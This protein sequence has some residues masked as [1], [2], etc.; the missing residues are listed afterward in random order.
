MMYL[1]RL[2][3]KNWSAQEEIKNYPPGY[4]GNLGEAAFQMDI[5]DSSVAE[6]DKRGLID[7]NKVGIIGFSRSG[8]YTEFILAHAKVHYAAATA[9]DNIQYSLGEY[10][11]YRYEAN[12]RGYNSLYGGPPYGKSLKNWLDYSISFNLNKIRTPLLMEVMG[13]G[14]PYNESKAPPTN[15]ATKWEISS[16]LEQLHIP[17]ELY[18]YP[19]EEHQPD[20]PQARLASL[21]RNVDWYRFWLQ[22]DERGELT[23]KNQYV[24][25]RVLR[26]QQNWINAH[27]N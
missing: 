15:L 16:A 5:W 1:M 12:I 13:Y 9:A 25:W 23:D 3:P 21:Q 8:W 11:H 18:Y 22:G 20:H 17:V 6:L 24:R 27:D 19:H 14:V 2:Y 7:S 10:W 26:E 4:P